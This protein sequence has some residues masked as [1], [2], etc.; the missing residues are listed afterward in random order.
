MAF[1]DASRLSSISLVGVLT[2]RQ[3][4]V[5]LLTISGLGAK[6]CARELGI[7]KRTV[8][9]HLAQAKVRAGVGSKEEL[10][11]WAVRVGITDSESR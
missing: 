2:P 7:S 8:E 6:E 9:D 4:K 3:R 11:A 1:T 10:I 5:V